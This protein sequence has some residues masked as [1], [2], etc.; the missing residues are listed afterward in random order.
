MTYTTN[1]MMTVAA[2]RR[3]RNGSVCFV[4]IGLPSKAANLARLTSAPD[5]VLIYESGP[6]GA[7]P[8]VLPLS[9]GDGELAET[10]D[11]VVSTS[12]IFRYWLQGGRVDVG[13]LGAAQVDRF[14][15]INTTVVGD[16]YHPKVRLPGAGGAPEIAGSAKSVLIILKQSA[17]AF[18]NKLDFITSVGHG[19]GGD[20]RKKLGLPGAGPVGIITDLCI[21]EPELVTHEFVVT[22]LHP[23]VTREQV[24]A[25]TGWDVRFA[26]SVVISDVPSNVELTALRDLEARTAAAHGQTPGEA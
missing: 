17:R 14:G 8:S 23:G 26:Q 7:K 1:E 20:S 16:Y 19:E 9:I 24:I 15:N 6:I 11:T 18:V 22:T 12:E 4:G 3:L 25:A 21:M 10:A 5:V 2:A 13:F